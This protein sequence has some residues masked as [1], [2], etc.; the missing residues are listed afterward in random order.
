[1]MEAAPVAASEVCPAK[2]ETEGE[3][4]RCKSEFKSL[5]YLSFIKHTSENQNVTI[6]TITNCLECFG[7]RQVLGYQETS[8]K[9]LESDMCTEHN[10]IFNK[11]KWFNSHWP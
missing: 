8:H 4:E 9:H 6:V 3:D 11:S 1:M 7:S 2:S 10:F 5:Y